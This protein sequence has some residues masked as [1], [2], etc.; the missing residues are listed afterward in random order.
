MWFNKVMVMMLVTMLMFMFMKMLMIPTMMMQCFDF[1]K[2]IREL[3]LLTLMMFSR[4]MAMIAI[5]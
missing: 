1:V 5:F 2:F 4:M 3:M